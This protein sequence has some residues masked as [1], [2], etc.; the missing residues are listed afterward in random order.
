[1]KCLQ[2]ILLGKSSPPT[3]MDGLAAF[4]A[5]SN[6][7][8]VTDLK[9]AVEVFLK[10]RGESKTQTYGVDFHSVWDNFKLIESRAVFGTTLRPDVMFRIVD[11]GGMAV[12]YKNRAECEAAVEAL[13]KSGV[14][15]GDKKYAVSL[16]EKFGQL[17]RYVMGS[18]SRDQYGRQVDG[19]ILKISA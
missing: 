17:S 9:T 4:N 11:S 18:G 5:P 1:M 6:V 13:C 19:C 2:P 16:V 15:V 10:H 7:T 3:Q 14:V 12:N 8:P